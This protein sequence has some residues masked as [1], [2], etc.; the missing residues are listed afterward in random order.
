MNLGWTAHFKRSSVLLFPFDACWS[1]SACCQTS[2]YSRHK[3]HEAFVYV[4]PLLNMCV[5]NVCRGRKTLHHLHWMRPE[6][7][8]LIKLKIYLNFSKS[9][10]MYSLCHQ[11]G[12]QQKSH[13]QL[14]YSVRII[15]YLPVNVCHRW[16]DIQRL[17]APFFLLR[18]HCRSI[19]SPIPKMGINRIHTQTHALSIQTGNNGWWET[20]SQFQSVQI[21]RLL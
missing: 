19:I 12:R 4:W 17:C 3:F 14:P 10:S 13:F 2:K 7:P 16:M 6:K 9:F 1:R 18:R 15:I 11:H 8:Y 5:W 21:V 20:K